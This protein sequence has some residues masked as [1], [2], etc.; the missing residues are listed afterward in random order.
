MNR[1][2]FLK[3]LAGLVAL[4]LVKPEVLKPDYSPSLEAIKAFSKTP[5]SIFEGIRMGLAA[6]GDALLEQTKPVVE[7]MAGILL[8]IVFIG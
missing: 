1:R 8:D 6:S 5:S 2:D 7:A 4:P 3:T